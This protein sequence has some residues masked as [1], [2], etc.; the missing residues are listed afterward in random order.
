M[1]PLTPWGGN[2]YWP[3]EHTEH[4]QN[5]VIGSRNKVVTA[6]NPVANI[7]MSNVMSSP[8]GNKFKLDGKYIKQVSL[9]FIHQDTLIHNFGDAIKIGCQIGARQGR[10]I[11]AIDHETLAARSY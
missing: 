4:D 9:T 5:K 2:R 3:C 1:V 10:K 8:V 11:I 6:E 7:I